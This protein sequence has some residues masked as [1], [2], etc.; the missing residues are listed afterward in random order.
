MSSAAPFHTD[1]TGKMVASGLPPLHKG[2]TQN[3]TGGILEHGANKTMKSIQQQSQHALKAG[4]TMKGGGQTLFQQG[5][6]IEGRTV[7]GVSSVGNTSKLL[8]NL[9]QLKTGSVYDSL[10]NATPS[11]VGGRKHKRKTNGKRVTRR[12]S[13]RNIRKSSRSRRRGHRT[14]RQ[15][16]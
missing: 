5:A 12:N 14:K 16:H 10:G 8:T 2:F 4:V 6:T 9:N 13:K 11:K 15:K 3:I 1:T 7:P